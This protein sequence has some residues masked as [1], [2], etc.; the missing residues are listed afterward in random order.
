M[1]GLG[2]DEQVNK[3]VGTHDIGYYEPMRLSFFFLQSLE[4]PAKVFVRKSAVINA[5]SRKATDGC[6]TE[7]ARKGQVTLKH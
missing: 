1:E 6:P 4:Q 5:S 7:I 2:K 3:E